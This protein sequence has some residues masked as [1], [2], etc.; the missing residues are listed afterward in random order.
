MSNFERISSQIVSAATRKKSQWTETYQINW[1]DLRNEERMEA[2]TQVHA[3]VSSQVGALAHSMMEF[4]CGLDRTSAFVRRV[5]VQN[6][7]PMSL[8]IMLLQHLAKHEK[9]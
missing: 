4:G 3:I 6:Q 8:R 5:A 2:A 9:G 1:H 7:L